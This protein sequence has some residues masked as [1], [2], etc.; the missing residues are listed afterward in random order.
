MASSPTSLFLLPRVSSQFFFFFFF[1]A[2]IL[3]STRR[4]A[5]SSGSC[6]R[7]RMAEESQRCRYIF[8]RFLFTN[9]KNAISVD[10]DTLQVF[11]TKIRIIE[12]DFHILEE[13]EPF[14]LTSAASLLV[15]QY[16]YIFFSPPSA[17]A[18]S[19]KPTLPL[20]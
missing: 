19:P 11:E 10:S 6:T 15:H 4:E 16:I 2:S 7:L 1:G 14:S 17:D 8:N 20:P 3:L 18:S 9:I 5:N 13:G 12:R